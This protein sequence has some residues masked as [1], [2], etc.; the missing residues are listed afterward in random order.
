VN[1][2]PAELWVRIS[3]EQRTGRLST[4]GNIT[5]MFA[6]AL[7]ELVQAD[8]VQDMRA[9][10]QIGGRIQLEARKLP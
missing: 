6:L 9:R 1:T 10:G 7:L 8:L 4:E 2:N 3:F 5:S